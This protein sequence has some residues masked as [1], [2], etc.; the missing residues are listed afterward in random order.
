MGES[1]CHGALEL[2]SGAINTQDLIE[3]VVL[4]VN[5]T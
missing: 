4:M 5:S 1:M 3:L 2:A